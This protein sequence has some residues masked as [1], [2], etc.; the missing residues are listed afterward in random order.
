MMPGKKYLVL[1]PTTLIITQRRSINSDAKFS[2]FLRLDSFL[3]ANILCQISGATMMPNPRRIKNHAILPIH[4]DPNVNSD[5]GNGVFPN[6]NEP[7]AM[8]MINMIIIWKT[9]VRTTALK[10]ANKR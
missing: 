9:S 7:T 8:L 6:K 5:S 2:H 3:V 1:N 4:I 10:P